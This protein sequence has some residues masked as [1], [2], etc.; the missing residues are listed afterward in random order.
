MGEIYTEDFYDAEWLNARPSVCVIVPLLL[1]LIRPVRSVIDLGCGRGEWPAMLK[2]T[3]SRIWL[4]NGS[5]LPVDQRVT[6][7]GLE[8]I[9]S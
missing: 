3:A 2:N 6:R 5:S 1:E 9:A 4:V 7:L 8:E